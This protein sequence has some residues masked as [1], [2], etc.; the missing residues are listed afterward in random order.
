VQVYED[1]EAEERYGAEE[2]V[3]GDVIEDEWREE[4]DDQESESEEDGGK[5]SVF[6]SSRLGTMNCALVTTCPS[7]AQETV[8]PMMMILSTPVS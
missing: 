1:S 8:T 4:L 6:V 7:C 5:T 2:E 3:E